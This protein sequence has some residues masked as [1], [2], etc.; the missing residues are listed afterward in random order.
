MD[1]DGDGVTNLEEFYVGTDPTRTD[2]DNDGIPDGYELAY[3]LNPTINDASLDLDQDGSSNIDEYNSDSDPDDKESV[4]GRGPLLSW[5]AP[6]SRTDGSAIRSAEID[7][8]EIQYYPVYSAESVTI[9]DNSGYFNMVGGSVAVSSYTPGYLGEGY[10]PIA[11]SNG[12]EFG[13]W[14]FYDLLPGTPYA[15]EARWTSERNRSKQASYRIRFK[16]DEK[17]TTIQSRAVDQRGSGGQ[18]IKVAEFTPSDSSAVVELPSKTDG[19]VIADAVR[20]NPN[21]AAMVSTITV[22]GSSRS[23]KFEEQLSSGTWAFKIKTVDS[24]GEASAFSEPVTMTFQ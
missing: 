23:V 20:L 4:P 16:S 5:T 18:W 19:Y 10:H 2:T 1:L 21:G 22:P 9:D 24:D 17:E 6:T 12:R 15:V 7:H 13:S 11:P 8:Y 3:G 14:S